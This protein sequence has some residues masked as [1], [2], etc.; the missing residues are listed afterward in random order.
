VEKKLDVGTVVF[1]AFIALIVWSLYQS[2]ANPSEPSSPSPGEVCE[3]YDADPT[4]Y[5][6]MVLECYEP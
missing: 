4:Q 2:F 5:Q 3:Y 1:W 6:D